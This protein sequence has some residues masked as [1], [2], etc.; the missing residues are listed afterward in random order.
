MG[1]RNAKCTT[2]ANTFVFKNEI[3][4]V[5]FKWFPLGFARNSRWAI[6][7]QTYVLP[8]LCA[9]TTPVAQSDNGGQVDRKSMCDELKETVA[10]HAA[11]M[12]LGFHSAHAG[13]YETKEKY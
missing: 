4:G 12:G 5:T 8:E 9:R 2:E 3:C 11:H 7:Q 10:L 6:G 13:A 1:K